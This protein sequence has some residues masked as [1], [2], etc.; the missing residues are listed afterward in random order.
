MGRNELGSTNDEIAAFTEDWSDS[1]CGLNPAPIASMA[2][3]I[4]MALAGAGGGVDTVSVLCGAG[5]GLTVQPASTSADSTATTT[6]Q[7]CRAVGTGFRVSGRRNLR[8]SAAW[9]AT[10]RGPAGWR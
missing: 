8:S 2:M 4:C 5:G 9:R 7:R 3:M 1:R 10:S 6:V